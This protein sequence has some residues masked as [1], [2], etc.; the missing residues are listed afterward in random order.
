MM[1]YD[2]IRCNCLPKN[3][4]VLGTVRNPQK[5]GFCEYLKSS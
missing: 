1:I 3:R 2:V 4:M 5:L